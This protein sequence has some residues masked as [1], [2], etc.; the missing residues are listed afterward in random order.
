MME[1]GEDECSPG[2]GWECCSTGGRG[3]VVGYLPA[4]YPSEEVFRRALSILAGVGIRHVEIGIPGGVGALEGGTIAGALRAVERDRPD[5]GG[6][7]EEAIAAAV[8]YRLH[9]IAMAFRSTVYDLFGVGE[10]VKRVVRAGSRAIL[11]PDIDDQDYRAL[12]REAY[13]CDCAVVPFIPAGRAEPLIPLPKEARLQPPFVYLQTADM[14][15]GGTFAADERIAWR[16]QGM[17]SSGKLP[18]IALGFGIKT[19]QNVTAALSMGADYAIVGT[20]MVD[21]LNEGIGAFERY[22]TR[23]VNREQGVA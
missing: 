17:K 12:A 16:I 8:S 11:V 15:T 23:L 3:G 2:H 1:I 4:C 20:A 10:F 7:M 9:P 21:A 13:R 19:A 5:I 6:V 14:P 22:V 18:P